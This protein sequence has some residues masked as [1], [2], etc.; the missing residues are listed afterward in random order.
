MRRGSDFRRRMVIFI[1]VFVIIT[2][3]MSSI[4]PSIPV[5][6]DG[7][8]IVGAYL[9]TLLKEGQQIAV[10]TLKDTETAEVDLFISIL[11]SSEESHEVTFFVPLGVDAVEF[12]V[13][14]TNS[15]SFDQRN[16]EGWD[17]VLQREVENKH[18]AIN[19]LF[20]ATLL[21]NGVWLMP[22]W[23]PLIL[24]GC[25]AP[26]PEATFETDSSQVSI[27]GLEADTDL[28]GLISTT[29]LDQ[30]VQETLSRLRGQKIAVVNLQTVARGDGG[31]TGEPR[32]PGDPGIQLSW[33][34]S[35]I[36]GETGA[37][38]SYPLG[39][40]TAWHHPIE[41]TRIYVVARP[42]IDIIVEYP[43][44]GVECSGYNKVFGGYQQRIF[45]NY[46]IAAFAVDEA[47]GDFGR[48]WRAVYTQSNA[49]EDIIVT[50][51]PQS[52]LSKF[53][54]GMQKGR[55]SG[56]VFSFGFIV[57]L[58][59]WLMAWRYLGPHLLPSNYHDNPKKLWKVALSYTGV[60]IILMIPGVILYAM[61]L[62][63]GISITLAFLFILFGGVSLIV[64]AAS[65]VKQLGLTF[66][67]AIKAYSI[68]TLVSNGAYLILALAYA[69][70]TG[71]I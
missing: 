8:P 13:R 19:Y 12:D 60:N 6:A 2:L 47:A 11:D 49:G 53:Y 68:V 56:L 23:L 15:L 16:T 70:L 28:E 25:A 9:W 67:Q 30:S 61:W 29:G 69:K 44:L 42:G 43:E 54:V 36:K 62:W 1:G 41:M 58:G 46:D 34:T 32:E 33:T 24:S 7:G 48:V 37:T 45:D 21:T 63:T 51:K 17:I 31:S 27:Y 71:V 66:K 40:G 18:E 5:R 14:E 20:G 35:L 10:V 26:P 59:L 3:F 22:F 65:R 52:A 38:Y 4:M 50:A 55:N 64:F 57:A 39:T